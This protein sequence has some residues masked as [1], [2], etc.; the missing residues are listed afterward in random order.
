MSIDEIKS[1]IH[2]HLNYTY[3][4]KNPI[5]KFTLED[6]IETLIHQNIDHYVQKFVT[7][8]MKVFDTSISED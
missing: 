7:N 6:L 5:L 1:G 4:V 8:Y 2:R 3:T